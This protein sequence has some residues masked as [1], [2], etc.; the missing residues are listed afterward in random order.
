[1]DMNGRAIETSKDSIPR[2]FFHSAQGCRTCE[3]TLGHGSGL[4]TNPDWVAS[5]RLWDATLLELVNISIRSP[6]GARSSQPWAE[7]QN[8]LGFNTANAPGAASRPPLHPVLS[9]FT[10]FSPAK[11]Q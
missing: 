3:A 10:S 2:G 1:M 6:R 5:N 4:I 11:P 9:P 8:P 7:E